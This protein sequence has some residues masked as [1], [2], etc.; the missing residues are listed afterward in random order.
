MLFCFFQAKNAIRI[1]L[2]SVGLGVIKRGQVPNAK[3]SGEQITE[4]QK[5]TPQVWAAELIALRGAI[6]KVDNA[7]MSY[8]Y[9][10][11]HMPLIKSQLSKGGIRLAGY[12]NTLFRA[13]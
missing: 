8:D 6:Y 7:V 2:G 13:E 4:W 5:A 3:I 11:Q 10:Y 12:L 1:L 9:V